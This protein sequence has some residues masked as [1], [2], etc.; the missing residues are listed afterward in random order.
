MD[1]D[2]ITIASMQSVGSLFD[3][4]ECI[5]FDSDTELNSDKIWRIFLCS[6][7]NVTLIKKTMFY[8][9][10]KAEIYILKILG[11]AK[12]NRQ[13]VP[14]TNTERMMLTNRM[15]GE[16]NINC[17][18]FI[19]SHI[20]VYYG[21]VNIMGPSVITY[22]DG[23][24]YVNVHLLCL[25]A[26]NASSTYPDEYVLNI[27]IN[28]VRNFEIVGFE[29]GEHYPVDYLYQL[30][31]NFCCKHECIPLSFR[32]FSVALQSLIVNIS[33]KGDV[34]FIG[35]YI[36]LGSLVRSITTVKGTICYYVY[37]GFTPKGTRRNWR[38]I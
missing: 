20:N 29:R 34:H 4:P 5:E 7:E 8:D 10:H 14:M 19:M 3:E 17:L 30:Y 22:P 11:D 23:K 15:I 37:I 25:D 36:P 21:M 6:E 26:L 2:I 35:P 38:H 32:D 18:N 12:Y 31:G 9:V 13:I 33:N 27:F 28:A 1:N 24:K 16:T